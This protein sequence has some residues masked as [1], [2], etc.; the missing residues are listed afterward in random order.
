VGI[1]CEGVSF[2]ENHP[3]K[4]LFGSNPTIAMTIETIDKKENA[5]LHR[6]EVRLL[7]IVKNRSAFLWRKVL[8]FES[9]RQERLFRDRTT[10]AK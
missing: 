3:D 2:A 7:T 6:H 10:N 8:S 5:V 9:R 4:T 1:G